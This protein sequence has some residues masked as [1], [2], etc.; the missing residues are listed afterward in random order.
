[1]ISSSVD[2]HSKA[3]SLNKLKPP[4]YKYCPRF[5]N[6]SRDSDH[7]NQFLVLLYDYIY[8]A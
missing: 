6:I 7:L 1:M 8:P 3:S 2:N 5:L 4:L